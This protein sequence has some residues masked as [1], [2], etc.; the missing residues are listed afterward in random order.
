VLIATGIKPLFGLLP[1]LR[2]GGFV[3]VPPTS[4]Q[5]AVGAL[6][7][8]ALLGLVAGFLPARRAAQLNPA[9]ALR[10]S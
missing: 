9:T 10:R 2:T 3:F 7:A 5:G 6:G 8:S 1:P 4:L